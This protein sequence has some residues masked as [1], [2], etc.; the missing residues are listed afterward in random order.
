MKDVVNIFHLLQQ[1]IAIKI[2][3]EIAWQAAEREEKE[4]MVNALAKGFQ[5]AI[6]ACLM[7]VACDQTLDAPSSARSRCVSST[8]RTA[9]AIRVMSASKDLRVRQC[10]FHGDGVAVAL[11]R[12]NRSFFPRFSSP[13]C[14][15]VSGRFESMAYVNL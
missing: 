9:R 10:P 12:S 8:G 15:T 3:P 11:N 2:R 7:P 6:R 1:L 4:R 5:I 13:H 14:P